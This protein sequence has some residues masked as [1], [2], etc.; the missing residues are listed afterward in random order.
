MVSKEEE[1]VL[2]KLLGSDPG[3]PVINY[4]SRKNLLEAILRF[5]TM[6]IENFGEMKSVQVLHDVLS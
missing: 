3:Y 5:Y 2:Q 1:M 4:K 6:H